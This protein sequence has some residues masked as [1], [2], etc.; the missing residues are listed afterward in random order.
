MI[1]ESYVAFIGYSDIFTFLNVLLYE[2]SIYL[3]TF[4]SED[5][6]MIDGK[7]SS[8]AGGGVGQHVAFMKWRLD[9]P[10]VISDIVL[11]PSM[12]ADSGNIAVSTQD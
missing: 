12:L 3:A 5:A 11:L 6:T 2:Y 8:V 1:S 10:H 9:K 7:G 4:I